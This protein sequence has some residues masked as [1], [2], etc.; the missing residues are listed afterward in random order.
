MLINTF[1]KEPMLYSTLYKYILDILYLT[2]KHIVSD[3]P[4]EGL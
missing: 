1:L 4:Y 3:L 2:N